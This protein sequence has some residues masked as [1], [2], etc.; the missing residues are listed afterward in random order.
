[1]EQVLG[2]QGKIFDLRVIS[3][4]FTYLASHLVE[5]SILN[6][7]INIIYHNYFSSNISIH[8]VFIYHECYSQYNF[9]IFELHLYNKDDVRY[10]KLWKVQIIYYVA[11]KY[12]S[13]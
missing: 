8:V 9:N 10:V 6:N 11:I 3:L 1:M 4:T 2:V 13:F 5:N 12:S 7:I